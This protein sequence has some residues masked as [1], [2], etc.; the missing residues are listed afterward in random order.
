MAFD[1][2]CQVT[3]FFCHAHKLMFQ[4]VAGCWSLQSVYQCKRTGGI[5]F[6][7]PPED[8]F[9][10]NKKQTLGKV[11]RNYRQEQVEG[12][13]VLGTRPEQRS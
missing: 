1:Q 3:G 4:E 6:L 7:V 8:L 5:S 13:L 2:L 12:S 10:D 9:G 11:L